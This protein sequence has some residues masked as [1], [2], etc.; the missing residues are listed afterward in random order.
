MEKDFRPK[1]KS[2]FIKCS[3]CGIVAVKDKPCKR[4]ETINSKNNP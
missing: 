2:P 3:R 4:C 1:P